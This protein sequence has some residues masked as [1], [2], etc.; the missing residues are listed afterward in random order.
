MLATMYFSGAISASRDPHIDKIIIPYIAMQCKLK[1]CKTSTFRKKSR[2]CSADKHLRRSGFVRFSL[3][4]EDR[5]IG[6]NTRENRPRRHPDT[7]GDYD[8]PQHATDAAE[9][10]QP[11]KKPA[12]A[13]RLRRV[14]RSTVAPLVQG[15]QTPAR[16]RSTASM[17]GS[18]KPGVVRT[19]AD[20][21]NRRLATC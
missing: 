20:H 6:Q 17:L 9:R 4:G 12:P 18:M 19:L 16:W 21:W 2:K 13:S 10:L 1:H 11:M 3:W 7:V 8:I 15:V 14:A 5:T